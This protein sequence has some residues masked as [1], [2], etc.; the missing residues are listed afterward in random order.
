M[1]VHDW[2]RVDAGLFH[3]FHQQWISGLCAA[4]NAGVLPGDYFAL[5]EQNISGP[6][7]DVLALH[8]APDDGAGPDNGAPLHGVATAPPRARLK[9]LTEVDLY[10]RKAD[11]ITV[12]HRHGDVVAVLEIV[13]PG[14]KANKAEFAALIAKTANLLRHGIHLLL[15]DL[16]PPGKRDPHGVHQALWDQFEDEDA[17]PP[18]EQPL[19]VAAYDAGP[20]CAAYVNFVA[21]GEALPDMPLFLKPQFY[22]EAPLEAT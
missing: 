2:T 22:V 19:T 8:L 9:R 6:I 18:S 4:L 3:A 5:P 17:A 1:P 11:R 10:A 12:Y 16:F 13:S 14:N 21:V 20:P 15:I 7:P